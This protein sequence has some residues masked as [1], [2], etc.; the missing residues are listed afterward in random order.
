MTAAF[1][2]NA[3][4]ESDGFIAAETVFVVVVIITGDTLMFCPRVVVFGVVFR[5]VL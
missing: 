1:V 2:G 5:L 3:V 4:V